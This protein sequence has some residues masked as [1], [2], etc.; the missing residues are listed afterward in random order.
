MLNRQEMFTKVVN[1]LASQQWQ[2]SVRESPDGKSTACQYRG[3]EGRRCGV[4]WIIRDDE[5]KPEME[6]LMAKRLVAYYGA[7]ILEG[8]HRGDEM[9]ESDL[10]FLDQ[11]QG[12]HDMSE[13]PDHMEERF[14]RFAVE[15]GLEWPLNLAQEREQENAV[16]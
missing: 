6:G 4:G 3:E 15:H 11:L 9:L 5:Y 8:F 14:R 10:E 16:L 1:G 13:S 12:H 2:K 7:R